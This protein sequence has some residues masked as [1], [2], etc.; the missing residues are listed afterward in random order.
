[1]IRSPTISYHRRLVYFYGCLTSELYVKFIGV[2]SVQCNAIIHVEGVGSSAYYIWVIML[3]ND[4]N[5]FL[6]HYI[7]Y[8]VHWPHFPI[9]VVAPSE[10]R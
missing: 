2:W 8:L 10:N 7:T 1:M 5:K 4:E 6:S 9:L 3:H